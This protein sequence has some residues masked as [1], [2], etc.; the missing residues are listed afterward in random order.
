M[1]PTT[2]SSLVMPAPI[3]EAVAKIMGEIKSL[4]KSEHN[5]H[6]QYDFAS[7]DAFLCAVGPLCAEAGIIV[8]QDEESLEMMQRG[9]RSWVRIT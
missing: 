7:I 8:I 3:A 5:G 1:E 4:P 2:S 6:G 9:D